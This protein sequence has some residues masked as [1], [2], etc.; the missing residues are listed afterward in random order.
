MEQ[1][2]KRAFRASLVAAGMLGPAACL[3]AQEA[4]Q[5]RDTYFGVGLGYVKPDSGA[6]DADTGYGAQLLFGWKL[7]RHWNAELA[8]HFVTLEDDERAPELIDYFLGDDGRGST[9]RAALGGDLMWLPGQGW[10]PYVVA[11]L[12]AAYNK[13]DPNDSSGVDLYF[14][15]GVGLMSAPLGS[16]GLRLRAEWRQVRDG[17]VD[18]PRD[19]HIFLGLNFPLRRGASTSNVGG[20]ARS[21]AP[22]VARTTDVPPPVSPPATTTSPP[23]EPAAPPLPPLPQVDDD[24]D[25]IFNAQDRCPDTL[26]GMRV[27][28]YG[29]AME[30]AIATLAGVRF[31]SGSARMDVASTPALFR[32]AAALE[33]QPSMRVE[34]RGHTDSIG[35]QATNL[36]LSEQRAGTVA[37]FLEGEGIEGWR[38]TVTGFGSSR[39]VADNAT[40]DGRASNRRVEIR[41]I[42][43]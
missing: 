33:G 5:G 27:D 3:A 9:S 43:P 35:D 30:G 15:Y 25:G 23:I 2:S 32:V 26:P 38:I 22:V 17:Y 16:Y 7:S 1:S 29:C 20:Q 19:G 36:R 8:T 31:V 37:R 28:Q 18:K 40:E 42:S 10:S 11:G 4:Q 24:R 6:R 14:N 13:G 39:P 41:V 21:T 34:L 12:G